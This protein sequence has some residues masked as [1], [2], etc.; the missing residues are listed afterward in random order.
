MFLQVTAIA[1]SFV[2]SMTLEDGIDWTKE[3]L[4]GLD[5]TVLHKDPGKGVM[6]HKSEPISPYNPGLLSP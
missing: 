1:A 3:G 4:G 6:P 2:I 5:I